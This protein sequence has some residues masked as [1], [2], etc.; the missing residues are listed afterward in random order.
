MPA[1]A[2]GLAGPKKGGGDA[3]TAHATVGKDL[4][5]PN[6]RFVCA[7]ALIELATVTA[8]ATSSMA[9]ARATSGGRGLAVLRPHVPPTG[10][11][12]TVGPGTCATTSARVPKGSGAIFASLTSVQAAPPARATEPATVPLPHASAAPGTPGWI[13]RHHS[14]FS[15]TMTWRNSGFL[16]LP[17]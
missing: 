4:G 2:M 12:Q 15:T 9:P 10:C 16:T 1:R 3:S 14:D 8:H 13:V 7:L 5:A 6:A 17:P 11:P